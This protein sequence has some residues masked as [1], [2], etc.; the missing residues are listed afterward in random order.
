MTRKFGP[1]ILATGAL[2]AMAATGCKNHMPHRV[3]TWPAS[4]DIVPTHPKPPEG[5]Y[6]ENW[7]PWAVELEVTP[8]ESVNP[9]MTQHVLIATVRDKNGEPLPNRRIEWIINEGGV[10]DIVEVDES[11]WRASRGYKVDNHYAVSHTNNFDHVLD[12]G[13]DDPSNDIAL[14]EGQ[15]WCVITSPIEGTSNITVYAP[16]IYDWSRHKVFVR[17]HWY[18]VQWECPP[19]ATNPVGTTHELVTHVSRY[20]DGTPLEGYQVTYT[21]LDG[22][23]ASF[24][25]GGT[26]ASVM[27]GPDGYARV[28]LQQSQPVEGTNNIEVDIMRMGNEACCEPPVHI[29]T[30]N[31]SKTWIGPDIA[32]T[33]DCQPSAL[34]GETFEYTINV[35]NPSEVPADNVVVTDN[36]PPGIQFVS[37]SPSTGGGSNLSWSLGTLPPGAT[38]TISVQVQGTQVGTFDNCANVTAAYNLQASDCCQTVIT[39]P[40]LSITKQCT[41][42][43][44]PCDTIEYEVVVTNTGDGPANNVR[45]TDQLPSGLALSDGASSVNV[46]LGTL[47][48]GEAK[49][50]RYS[51]RANAAGTYTNTAR[52]VGDGGLGAEASC[53]TTVRT[54]ALTVSK[55]G[56]DV[57]FIGRQF[58]YQITVNSTGDI[59][60]RDV[61]LTDTLPSNVQF[62]S[63]SDGGR[64]GQTVTWN[65][66]TIEP[67]GS[68]TVTVTVNPTA[69]GTARNVVNA[70]A[71]CAEASAE[72]TNEIRG[73]P[74]ILLEVVDLQDPIEVGTQTTYVIVVTNQG[75]AT[76]TN[77][78][79]VATLPPQMRYIS[80]DGLPGPATADGPTITFPPV[81]SLAPGARAEYR[82]VVEG[83]EP[84]DSRFH[85]SMTSDQIGDPPVQETESTHIYE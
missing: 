83:A 59:A 23:A 50:V 55:T 71:F 60:A 70:Q 27:T 17:K 31:T 78:R 38:S 5:G 82:V 8:V 54:P 79:I 62:V 16:G 22:P 21:I 51:A 66:G 46:D 4:G 85:V 2:L 84:A 9:V 13:D 30:C 34:V 81:P 80:S 39:A 15:S 42:E 29:A 72:F 25:Q 63:A 3:F 26:T 73:I 36:L 76:G 47:G 7:D 75:S 56:P 53:T 11:G 64:G 77:I 40:A 37:S 67:G 35:T 58:D 68:R 52:V 69:P 1:C 32:I 28:T 33:K 10:G 6:Y 12:L 65:L 44:T 19:P 74:A 14:T 18:D 45:L 24:A 57:R 20:S 43:V 41:P 48:A 49:R 61:V